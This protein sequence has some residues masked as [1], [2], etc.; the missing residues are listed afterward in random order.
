MLT[1]TSSGLAP[2]A[3]KTIQSV[4]PPRMTLRRP[5]SPHRIGPTASPRLKPLV[6]AFSVST[7][8]PLRSLTSRK[9]RE[10]NVFGVAGF[11]VATDTVS[12]VSVPSVGQYSLEVS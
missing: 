4:P 8:R 2:S 10:R 1:T 5:V 9:Y 11:A 6:G 12:R 3:L 7:R